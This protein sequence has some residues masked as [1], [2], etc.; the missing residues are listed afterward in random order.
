MGAG[1]SVSRNL[2][3]G[4]NEDIQYR[5]VDRRPQGLT[6]LHDAAR[7]RDRRNFQI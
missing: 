5:W 7:L 3:D 4:A 1:V 6:C 2:M